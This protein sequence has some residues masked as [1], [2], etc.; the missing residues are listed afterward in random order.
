METIKK[1]D[2]FTVQQLLCKLNDMQCHIGL[3]TRNKEIEI[4]NAISAF[5]VLEQLSKVELNQYDNNQA[6]ETVTPFQGPAQK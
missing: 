4:P 2:F 1:R 5:P 3:N 6:S